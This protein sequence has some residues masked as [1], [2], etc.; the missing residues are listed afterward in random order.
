MFEFESPWG[1][2]PLFGPKPNQNELNLMMAVSGISLLP[3]SKVLVLGLGTGVLVASLGLRKLHVTAVSDFAHEQRYNLLTWIQ[4]GLDESQLI[5]ADIINIPRNEYQAVVVFE[6]HHPDLWSF[7]LQEARRFG[8][9]GRPIL[10]SGPQA[11]AYAEWKK[12]FGPL[13]KEQEASLVYSGMISEGIALSWFSRKIEFS[14]LRAKL[15]LH[16]ACSL[17][18]P[19]QAENI[20]LR[21]YPKPEQRQQILIYGVE[22]ILTAIATAQ[23]HRKAKVWFVSNSFSVI[24][25]TRESFLATGIQDQGGFLVSDRLD[26]FQKQSMDL[27]FLF[28]ETLDS[29]EIVQEALLKI[30]PGNEI[31]VICLKSWAHRASE[32]EELADVK[33]LAEDQ[34][35]VVL[36]LIG[37]M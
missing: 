33:I 7:W 12:W 26:D 35:W 8:T 25:S 37:R 36:R 11:S 13:P 29:L 19:S 34:G 32:L 21:H 4:L 6:P 15:V 20:I 3:G 5:L 22:G 27:I 16:P 14:P 17:D 10:G 24:W 23:V 1:T 31:R 2:I 28:L 9:P 18:L 30:K